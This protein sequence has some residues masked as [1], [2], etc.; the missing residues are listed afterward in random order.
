MNQNNQ[1]DDRHNTA[2]PLVSA[3]DSRSAAP[4]TADT[5]SSPL[6]PLS[7]PPA[8]SAHAMADTTTDTGTTNAG[9]TGTTGPAV[10]APNRL[11]DKWPKWD[12]D[13]NSFENWLFTIDITLGDPGMSPFLGT[14]AHICGAL[15]AC[16]PSVKQSECA[17]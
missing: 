7:P 14:P 6:S 12:G 8:P 17:A 3:W 15:F 1:Q 11:Y 16:I 4:T 5:A 9:T 13:P 2:N 10:T